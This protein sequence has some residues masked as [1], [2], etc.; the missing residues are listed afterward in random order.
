V[1]TNE[2]DWQDQTLDGRQ[3]ALADSL[4]ELHRAGKGLHVLSPVGSRLRQNGSSKFRASARA[5][6]VGWS[7]GVPGVIAAE[8]WFFVLH[9]HKY[10]T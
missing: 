3:G 6:F 5:A 2:I 1:I 10:L 9:E 4:R 7:A 8:T